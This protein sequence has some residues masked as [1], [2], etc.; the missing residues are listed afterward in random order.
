MIGRS[1]R[2]GV[3]SVRCR[4]GGA[5]LLLGWTLWGSIG[6]RVSPGAFRRGLDGPRRCTWLTFMDWGEAAVTDSPLGRWISLCVGGPARGVHFK[7]IPNLKNRK[8]RRKSRARAGY[9]A[10]TPDR[11]GR[12]CVVAVTRVATAQKRP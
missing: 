1:V 9:L 3:R 8:I 11:T 4:S 6:S 2:R 5:A 7:R 12:Y 10:K